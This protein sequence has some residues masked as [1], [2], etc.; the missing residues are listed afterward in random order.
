MTVQD[1]ASELR[2]PLDVLSKAALR[3]KARLGLSQREL[4][5]ILGASPAA[6][7]RAARTGRLPADGKTVELAVLFVR[8]FRAL[9]AIVGGDE[10]TARAWLR[11]PNSALGTTPLEAMKTITGLVGTLAYLDSRRALV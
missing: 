3:A 8:V 6:V 4:G 1:A 11:N 7:S 2:T 9:D 10:E 5:A